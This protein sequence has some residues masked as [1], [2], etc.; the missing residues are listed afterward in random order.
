M[1]DAD[2]DPEL[3]ELLAEL[4]TTL[5]ELEA[6]V[7][8]ERP[9][10]PRLP[11]TEELARFTSEVAIPG[12][13]L[14]LRTNVRALQLLQR[15]LRLADGRDPSPDGAV[16][17]ARSR[18]EDVGRA[19]LS[20]LD[21]VLTDLQSAL[22]GR[23]ENEQ[24]NELL[25]RARDLREEVEN[26]LTADGTQAGETENGRADAGQS[27]A[28]GIDIESELQSLKDNLDEADGENDQNGDDADDDSDDNG[29]S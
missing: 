21:D 2:S 10:G 23:S 26:E 27:E 17:E 7:E 8:R 5:Q 4:T 6:E 1:S 12:L 28:V 29:A 19:S 11:T 24:A 18:A 13:I 9:R 22:D 20:Q 16:T 25:D 14:L 15:A 3:R